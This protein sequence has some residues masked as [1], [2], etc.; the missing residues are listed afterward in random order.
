M[1]IIGQCR[2]H[3]TPESFAESMH[4]FYTMA[5]SEFTMQHSSSW[6]S[7]QSSVGQLA[8]GHSHEPTSGGSRDEFDPNLHDAQI[9]TL[10]ADDMWDDDLGCIA[11]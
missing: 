4:I 1:E 5:Q 9:D 2:K 3:Q 8:F 11:A 7:N 10:Y 6:S